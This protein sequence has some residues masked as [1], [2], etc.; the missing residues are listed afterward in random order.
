MHVVHAWPTDS[1]YIVCANFI[2][3]ICVYIA[4]LY[5]YVNEH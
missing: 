3:W 4:R 5:N 1:Y 2:Y